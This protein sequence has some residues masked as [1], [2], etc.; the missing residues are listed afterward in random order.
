VS[1]GSPNPTLLLAGDVGATKTSLA[2]YREADAALEPVRE[3]AYANAEFGT[4]DDLLDR[5][6]DP[7]HRPSLV[8]ACFGVAGA[9]IGGRVEMLNLE[10]TL[11]AEA[12]AARLGVR[13]V[14]L[15]NDLEAAA[16]GMLHLPASDFRDLSPSLDR[17]RQ[18]NIGV[19]AAGTG[20]GEA[21]CY[22][23]G[24]EHHPIASEG[25]HASFA[26]TSAIEI[27]LLAHLRRVLGGHVSFERVLSGSGL[28]RIYEF[29]RD[30][31]RAEEPAALRARLATGSRPEI[32]SSAGL[33][34]TFPICTQALDLFVT[35]Y[36][37]EAGNLA[38]TGMT[39]G[40][41]FVG[42]GIAPKILPK[43]TD[44]TFLASFRAKGRRRDITSRIPVDVALNAEA[45]RIG[46]A[47][48]A[49]RLARRER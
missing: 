19:I 39:L 33:A 48:F 18:G 5:F 1:G 35:I 41:M 15:L 49:R 28:V 38:L 26:P 44:G 37:A 24:T 25:G 10:W 46:A 36:G 30:S 20:L 34:R 29:L 11:E 47:H 21:L 17:T 2:L 27:D 3:T 23:D 6:L 7:T 22:W 13:R 43:L 4:F 32:I 45:P 40:G 12:L 42:G 14:A 8:A 16:Y 31:G 9:V